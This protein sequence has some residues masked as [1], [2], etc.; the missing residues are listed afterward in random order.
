MIII[1]A[2]DWGGWASATD[3]ALACHREGRITSVSAMVFMADSE[4]AAAIA[5]ERSIDVG[6]HLNLTTP[7]SAPNCPAHL[8]KRQREL[9]GRLPRP[10][11]ETQRRH[12]LLQPPA[13][14]FPH[15]SPCDTLRALCSGSELRQ[16]A[17]VCDDSA[18]AAAQRIADLVVHEGYER[19]IAS[20]ASRLCRSR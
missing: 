14:L 12:F 13:S 18:C 3:A 16:F 5:Q 17:E 1:N 9:A 10:R 19:S 15:R 6:L 7:F 2:D 8:S 11:R 20:S 4:R